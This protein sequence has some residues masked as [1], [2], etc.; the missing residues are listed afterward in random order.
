MNYPNFKVCCRCFTFNQSMYITD[1]MNGFIMQ[2]TSFPFVCTIVDDASTDGEQEVIR[3]YV[4]ENFD[5]SEGSV[6]FKKET[7][8]AF[9]TFAQHKT[10]KNCYF[11]V[12][13][14]KENHYSKG[15]GNQKISYLA[16]WRDMCEYEALCEGDD[17]WI[18]EMK[19]L[20]QVDVMDSN[21]ECS[22][23]VGI[24]ETINREGQPSG[25]FMPSKSY[26]GLFDLEK[27]CNQQFR[28]G[29]WFGHTS[30][31]FFRRETMRELEKFRNKVFVNFPYGDI[32]V[33]LGCLLLGYG[34][35]IDDVL[36]RY[37]INSGGFNS[38]LLADVDKAIQVE[39]KLIKGMEDFDVYTEKKYHKYIANRILW[40]K[41]IIDYYAS[42][43]NGLVYLRPKYWKIA[44]TQGLRTTFIMAI[45]S[46]APV[47]YN[48][49][50]KI[51][52]H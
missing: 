21:K 22:I 2:Q 29:Q 10:N 34:Y 18:D 35:M 19:L 6:A 28:L 14:L 39:R 49:I 3:K 24:T 13:Y 12:L 41:C 30:S 8:Y 31:F 51:L 46:I 17:Y 15:M 20:K 38:S 1:T 45:K 40:S 7:D 26:S 33:M 36:S 37:R 4:D 27:F 25:K 32:V 23:C 47:P 9:I 48:A 16:E 5:F 11:A 42:G 43:R 44:K 50:K 52:K